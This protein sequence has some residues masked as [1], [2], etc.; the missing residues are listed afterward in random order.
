MYSVTEF[1]DLACSDGTLF[2]LSYRLIQQYIVFQ[3]EFGDVFPTSQVNVVQSL[4]RAILDLRPLP[5]LP[6]DML[7][8]LA[9]GFNAWHEVIPAFEYQVDKN[10]T[11]TVGVMNVL[12]AT[13]LAY[14]H[15]C[16]LWFKYLKGVPE[17]P[18]GNLCLKYI[19]FVSS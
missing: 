19:P 4:L 13:Y 18:Q 8:A 15:V 10:H 16:F 5:P 3:Y 6:V 11:H 2:C 1:F 9:V 14:I 17:I 7:G 12:N